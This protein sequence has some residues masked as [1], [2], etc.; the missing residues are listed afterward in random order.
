[1]PNNITVYEGETIQLHCLTQTGSTVQWLHNNEMINLNLMR[2]YEMLPSGGLRI[3]SA[4]KSDS[5]I[6]ECVASKIGFSTN[7]AKCYVHIQGLGLNVSEL[8]LE[9]LDI[10]QVNNNAIELYWKTSELIELYIQIQYRLNTPKV[11]WIIDETIYNNT[12]THGIISNLEYDQTYKFR[13]MAF[14]SNG[15]QL[16]SSLPKRFALKFL[17]QFYLPIPQITDAWITTDGKISLKWKVNDSFSDVIDGYIIYYRSV[18]SNDNY[19]TITIP[20]LVYPITDTF[21]ISSIELNDKYEI[22][23]ATYSNR[24][25]SPMS[26][27]IEISLPS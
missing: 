15:K 1:G 7:T 18:N 23:M 24:G 2:R 13:L 5:G 12:I 25:L 9:I 21:T 6:Y 14:D 20:N 8:K 17:N 16:T 27:S 19:T 11:T 22:R 26:N 3:V 10:K 4:Q